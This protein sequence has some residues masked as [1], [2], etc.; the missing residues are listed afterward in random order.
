[1]KSTIKY[2]Y[3]C[4]RNNFIKTNELGS[5]FVVF[6]LYISYVLALT[7]FMYTF[8]NI[9]ANVLYQVL[10]I[11][12][13]FMGLVFLLPEILVLLLPE[14]LVFLLPEIPVIK[15]TILLIKTS[16]W[17]DIIEILTILILFLPIGSSISCGIFGRFIGYK[18]SKVLSSILIGIT[19][20][21]SVVLF[22]SIGLL[23]TH[24]FTIESF[25][26]IRSDLLH[27]N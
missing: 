17:E 24:S 15:L 18:G 10:E 5:L 19:Y 23:R 13:L 25:C 8:V 1:M 26:W 6:L 20:F 27:V 16:E 21:S 2:I 3:I 14:I 9:I 22:Y 11:L 12:I 4:L 7:G